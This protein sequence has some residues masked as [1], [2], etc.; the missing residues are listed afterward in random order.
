[1]RSFPADALGVGFIAVSTVKERSMERR[2]V[3]IVCADVAGYP[4]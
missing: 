2:L 4:G 3:T 1:L